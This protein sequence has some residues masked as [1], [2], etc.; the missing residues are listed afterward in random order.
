MV[1]WERGGRS[2]WL[3]D[4]RGRGRRP[5][6]GLPLALL[7]KLGLPG[8]LVVV[9]A[10]VLLGPGVLTGA[11]PSIDV[12]FPPVADEDPRGGGLASGD[13]TAAFV[14][15]LVDDIQEMWRQQFNAAEAVYRPANLVLFSSAT[16]T[17]CGTGSAATGPFY[18]PVDG[19]IYI[20][21]GVLPSARGPV[22]GAGRLRP[23]VRCGA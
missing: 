1:R 17:G 12:G 3:E 23:G 19:R 11:E 9:I 16:P 6:S 10:A 5:A 2:P 20:D 14:N 4:R 13:G 7:A 18:C 21:L 15:F 8:L 22:R